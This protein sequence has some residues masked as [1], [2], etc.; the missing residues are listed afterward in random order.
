VI[1]ELTFGFWRYLSSA[2]HEVPLWRPYLHRAGTS[3]IAVDA[4]VTR[5][6]RPRNRAAHHEPLLHRDRTSD[7]M[8]LA[9]GHLTDGYGDL[10]V[11][12][13]RI[14]NDLQAYIAA[15]SSCPTIRDGTRQDEQC[16]TLVTSSAR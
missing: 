9:T 14:S 3:R 1:A 6:H 5:L 4:P 7:L 15:H 12:A 16:E 13:G 10:L 8:Q 11:V 2:A